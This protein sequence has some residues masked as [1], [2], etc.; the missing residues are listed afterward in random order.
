MPFPFPPEPLSYWAFLMGLSACPLGKWP[1]PL[2]EVCGGPGE[3][4]V[5]THA[6]LDGEEP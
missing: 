4:E 5:Q 6:D 2:L 3:V 1:S